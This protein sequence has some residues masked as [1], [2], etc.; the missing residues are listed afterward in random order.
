VARAA[1]TIV[2]CGSLLAGC[3]SLAHKAPGGFKAATQTIAVTSEPAGAR[4]FLDNQ[5]IGMTPMR[6]IVKRTHGRAVIRIEHDAFEAAE[7][8]LTRSVSAWT[9]GN[10]AFALL[11][12]YPGNRLDDT[13]S[14]GEQVFTAVG[15][16]LIGLGIDFLNGSA[17]NFSS[18]VH[19]VLKPKTRRAG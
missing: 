18:S 11:A 9:A 12:V 6:A 3:A 5:P 16:P 2:I 14:G 7:V 17:Y 4:V 15:L 8:P 19:V 10:L 1:L 13:P